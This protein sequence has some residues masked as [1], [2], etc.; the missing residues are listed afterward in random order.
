MDILE[1][2]SVEA[3]DP[4]VLRWMQARN[5]GNATTSS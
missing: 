4:D 1:R 5:A 3:Q 2:S